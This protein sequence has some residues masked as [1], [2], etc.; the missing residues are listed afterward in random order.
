MAHLAV[1]PLHQHPQQTITLLLWVQVL[2]FTPALNFEGNTSFDYTVT[3]N[4]GLVSNQATITVS[5]LPNNPPIANNK[6]FEILDTLVLNGNAILGTNAI[7]GTADSDP[8]GHTLTI[9]SFT[10]SNSSLGDLNMTIGGDGS[11]I[12][13]PVVG[14]GGNTATFTYTIED[15]F[16]GTADANITIN[17]LVPFADLKTTKTAPATV[18]V[19][20]PISYTITI[21]SEAGTQYTDAADVRVVDTLPSG[22]LFNGFTAPSGWVCAFVGGT[23]T[24]DIASYAVGTTSTLEINGFAPNTA[25][26]LVNNATIISSTPDPDLSNN[27]SNASTTV[28][29]ADVDMTITKTASPDPVIT[30]NLLTYTLTVRNNGTENATGVIVEDRLDSSLLFV[31]VDGGGDWSCSQGSVILC[32]YTANGGIFL[33]GATPSDIDIKVTTPV[34][35][36]DINNTA[37]VKSDVDDI[38]NSNNEAHITITVEDGTAHFEDDVPLT[39]YLQYNIFGDTKLIGNANINKPAGDT[40]RDYNNQI[41]MTFVDTDS[42]PLTYNSSSSRLSLQPDYE[43]VWAGLYWAG[44]ICRN[45][46]VTTGC[47]YSSIPAYSNYSQAK[48]SSV[49][50]SV[51]LKTPHST[52]NISANTLYT[53]EKNLWHP[54]RRGRWIEV[55]KTLVYS[56]F[57]DITNLLQKNVDGKYLASLNNGLYTVGNIMT[58]EGHNGGMSGT[59]NYGGWSMLTIYKDLNRTLHFKNIS[60]FNGFQYMQDDSEGLSISGFLT[61]RNGDIN[62]SISYFTADGD[63]TDGGNVQMLDTHTSTYEWVGGDVLNPIDNLMNSTIGEYS[64]LTYQP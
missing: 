21:A 51:K 39:K 15:G 50:G 33:P 8:D 31:S 16:G 1:S 54:N 4:A 6:T 59:G 23:V 11:F 57:T 14:K 46:G 40:D 37:T 13:T 41:D 45:G 20:D 22:F 19:G 10:Y 61:P 56:A 55:G 28:G 18:T 34:V 60:L 53:I 26:V 64:V 63:P 38:D 36:G 24:C 9:T 30:T 5:I 25:G 27:D 43:I 62:A 48:S 29:A 2:F 42:D 52:Y 32:E 3:D 12:F 47:D 35:A 58:T 17:L 44:H 7:S 49:L